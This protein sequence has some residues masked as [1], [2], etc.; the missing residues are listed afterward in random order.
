[1]AIEDFDLIEDGHYG[2][3]G[4]YA[5]VPKEITEQLHK[6]YLDKLKP[7]KP[8]LSKYKPQDHEHVNFTFNLDVDGLVPHSSD[9]YF[10]K[11]DSWGWSSHLAS[12]LCGTKPLRCTFANLFER[13]GFF[14]KGLVDSQQFFNFCDSIEQK[15]QKHR[16]FY[17]NGIHGTDVL[18]TVHVMINSTG[19]INFLDDLEILAILFAAA[20]H[21]VEHTGTTNDFHKDT[22]SVL[23]QLYNNVS[24]LENHHL[25]TTWNTLGQKYCNMLNLSGSQLK[26]FKELVHEMILHTDLAKHFDQVK[27]INSALAVMTPDTWSEYASDPDKPIPAPFDKKSLLALVLHAAD[28]SNA[29]KPWHLQQLF[30]MQIL[31]EFFDQ[32][33]ELKQRNM[34]LPPL[35]NRTT[36]N[37]PDSQIGFIAYLVKP[38]YESISNCLS[39]MA[40]VIAARAKHGSSYIQG[41][42]TASSI[43]A[44]VNDFDNLW[45]GNLTYN[46][47]RWGKIKIASNRFARPSVM[48]KN[49]KILFKKKSKEQKP[50]AII[51]DDCESEEDQEEDIKFIQK[52][53]KSLAMSHPATMSANPENIPSEIAITAYESKETVNSEDSSSP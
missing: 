20:C 33:D 40:P 38:L 4:P 52:A 16:N 19:L 43:L 10:A 36:T 39:S 34:S 12:L 30:T 27:S 18:Q 46:S 31:Q 8:K 51:E 28:I 53:R 24:V 25:E 1:M 15:Y 17:H 44:T 6:A 32:G 21:D 49:P 2:S 13:Y 45:R 42:Q 5:C 50:E 3:L 14:R 23:A 41:V 7:I 11:I 35:S 37:I 47:N 48:P 22:K 26:Y 29:A 9:E